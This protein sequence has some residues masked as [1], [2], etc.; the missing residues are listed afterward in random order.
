MMISKNEV[1]L[2]QSRAIH[3][4]KKKKTLNKLGIESTFLSL[5][6]GICE[7]PTTSIIFSGER[8]KAFPVG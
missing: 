2:T 3:D 5:L 7:K 8:I 1:P 4:K 6:T